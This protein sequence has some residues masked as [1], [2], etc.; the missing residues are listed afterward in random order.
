MTTSRISLKNDCKRSILLRNT[1]N[2]DDLMST[3][4]NPSLDLTSGCC[5]AN[6][7]NEASVGTAM[8]V[9]FVTDECQILHVIV[10][11]DMLLKNTHKLSIQFKPKMKNTAACAYRKIEYANN[12]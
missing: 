1:V 4:I 9:N 12:S 3:L 7:S 10:S 11:A 5:T 6:T 2:G 8:N